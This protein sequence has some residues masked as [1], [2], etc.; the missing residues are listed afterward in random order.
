MSDELGFR[1]SSHLV[2]VKID[3][4]HFVAP[5]TVTERRPINRDQLS[6]VILTYN[7]GTLMASKIAA[8]FL[9]G[10]RGV[11]KVRYNE[12][13]RDIYDLLW[14]MEK[15]PDGNHIVP[16]FD[17]L[18]AKNIDV[19]DLRALF[20]KLT[21]KMND[22]SDANLKQDLSP[23][24]VNR[25]FIENWLRNWRESYLRL[26]EDYKI[27]TV[28]TLETLLIREDFLKDVFSFIYQYNTEEGKTAYIIYSLHKYW[29]TDANLEIPVDEKIKNLAEFIRMGISSR[30]VQKDTLLQYATL[31]HQKTENYLKKTNRV[32]LGDNLVTKVIRMTSDKLNQKEEIV[33]NVS[34]LKSCELDDLLK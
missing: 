13:G 2:H 33:L 24:F 26:L 22:V 1:D 18:A 11:G 21:L 34:T 6:F 15:S 3:L 27:R 29:I 30:S 8:I 16:D 9:R 25:T 7:M 17:Y 28:T 31:F 10:S 23:L 32:M 14:Y 20:D 19:K 5:K 4:N 12:K